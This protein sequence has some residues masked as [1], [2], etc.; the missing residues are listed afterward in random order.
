MSGKFS[1]FEAPL[2]FFAIRPVITLLNYDFI[3]GQTDLS[4]FKLS[5]LKR[6]FQLKLLINNLWHVRVLRLAY[7]LKVILGECLLR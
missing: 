4:S 3:E 5:F 1:S 7:R 2:H 6:Y